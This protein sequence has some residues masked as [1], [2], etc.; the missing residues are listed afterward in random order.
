M[1]RFVL[2]EH[3]RGP[4]W[5]AIIRHNSLGGLPID[6][7]RIGDPSDLPLGTDDS[8]VLLWAERDGRILVTEDGHTMPGHLAQHI[9]LGHT[10]PGIFVIS[11]GFSI[12][13]IVAYL[14]LIAH[15]GEATDYENTITYVP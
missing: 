15:A 2:D 8:N 7:A 1:L 11:A 9:Q 10:A 14:E 3:L 6:A 13:E 4:L 5:S 12:K